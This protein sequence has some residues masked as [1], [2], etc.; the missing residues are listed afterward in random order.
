MTGDAVRYQAGASTAGGLTNGA[1]YYVVVLDEK[2]IRLVTTLSEATTLAATRFNFTPGDVASN[3]IGVSCGCA[4][5]A[6]LTY[7]APAPAIFGAGTVN[8]N[9]TYDGG[10][11]SGISDNDGAW[12]IFI[13]GGHGFS[14]GEKV[15]YTADPGPV[16]PGLVSGGV[17]KVKTTSDAN[18]L[19]LQATFGPEA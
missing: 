8:V 6:P 16:I 4:S 9:V 18:I 17:Y 19:Q 13:S 2:T 11:V 3:T 15:L 10:D 7:H 12:N 1:L 5:G 14:N